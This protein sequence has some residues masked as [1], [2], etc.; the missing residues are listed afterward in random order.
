MSTVKG[1]TSATQRK[2]SPGVPTAARADANSNNQNASSRTA[3]SRPASQG[4]GTS[5]PV[6][7]RP[8]NAKTRRPATARPS[9]A[10]Q[11]SRPKDIALIAILGAVVI[12]LVILLVVKH[13]AWHFVAMFWIGGVYWVGSLFN[14]R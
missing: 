7:L 1:A 2:V 6:R 4:A 3:S 10:V 14:G 9:K 5:I 8:S 13:Y 11:Q 12:S